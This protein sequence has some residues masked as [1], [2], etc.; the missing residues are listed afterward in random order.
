MEIVKW[1]MKNLKRINFYCQ[2]L[3]IILISLSLST[4]LVSQTNVLSFQHLSSENG[5]AQVNI[6]CI[7][8]DKD[9]F[10][11]ISSNNGISRY[12]GHSLKKLQYI[13]DDSIQ[14]KFNKTTCIF[15]DHKSRMLIGN[16]FNV[17]LYDFST[18]MLKSFIKDSSFKNKLGN[19]DV[20]AITEDETGTIWIGTRKGLFEYQEKNNSFKQYLHDTILTNNEDYY[21]NRITDLLPDMHGTIWIG[22]LY[23]VYKFSIT[24]HQFTEP[25]KIDF[26]L[27]SHKDRIVS[28]EFD[29]NG[30]LWLSIYEHGINILDTA[31][32]EVT[33]IDTKTTNGQLNSNHISKLICDESGKM[34]IAH[35]TKGINLY[36]PDTK[37]FESFHHDE[38]DAQ[39]LIDDRIN[40]IFKD[41][42][43]TIWI[44]TETEGIDRVSRIQSK[45]NTYSHHSE[46]SNSPC[47]NGIL[48]ACE[49]SKNNLWIGSI[50]GLM[51]FDRLKNS[52]TCFHHEENN[53]NSLSDNKIHSVSI[54][55]KGLVW[56]GTESG[57]NVYNPISG[58]WKHYFP[59]TKNPG[60]LSSS[61]INKICIRRN[62]EIWFGTN[63][64]ICRYQPEKDQ[65]ETKNN[66]KNISHIQNEFYM[67]LYEDSKGSIWAA[68]S[69]GGVLNLADSFKI[70]KKYAVNSKD[71][72][73][74]PSNSVFDFAE[75]N[76]GN[77][78]MA[79][80]E[81]I[82]MLD[83]KT[84]KFNIYTTSDG[85]AS[86]K[87]TQVKIADDGKIWVGTN[88]GL[89]ELF[90]DKNGKALIKNFNSSDGLQ[91]NVFY[92][93]ASLKLHSG[94]FLFGGSK[95]FNLF[96]PED[97]VFNNKIPNVLLSSF[98]ILDKEIDNLSQVIDLK[99]LKLSHTQNFFSFDMAAISFDYPEKNQYA[100]QL[101]GFDKTMIHC[102]NR[103][104]VS[105]T[106]VPPGNYTL[107]IIA[108]NN[109][110]VWNYEGL[111][112]QI[113]ITPPYWMTW[114]F[115]GFVFAILFGS[116]ILLVRY[117]ST[118]KLKKQLVFIE[119][120]REI[121]NIRS[122][123]SRDIHDEIGSGLTR[124]TALGEMMKSDINDK[125]ESV[126]STIN[127]I[128]ASSQEIT[129]NLSEIVWTINPQYDNLQSLLSYLRY[130]SS[131]FFEDSTIKCIISFP[132]D[133]LPIQIHPDIKRNIFLAIKE[134]LNNIMKHSQAKNV[135][136]TFEI[137]V[138]KFKLIIADD[139]VGFEERGNNEFGNGLR[140]I[141]ARMQG[142]KAS[143]SI[144]SRPGKGTTII[145]EGYLE[146]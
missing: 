43:G 9:G 126:P 112:I 79:T 76:N 68:T 64:S 58:K 61:I 90:F 55:R 130:Y 57:L 26:D 60:S 137:E 7:N 136:I 46:H 33:I 41:D 8:Q 138:R 54:D 89:S 24:T 53:S 118:R 92:N 142:I 133:V 127:K 135:F 87:I 124:I 44:G 104:H 29:K 31:T 39:S 117:I 15:R 80:S 121:E 2:I 86:N 45:F 22:T 139:G 62:G 106:N 19:F 96:H 10:I 59:D 98:S 67:A 74:I 114:Y 16:G 143:C 50:N 132:S 42:F 73:S 123:I 146:E 108:S 37:Y 109:D 52:F 14:V 21:R 141:S 113:E 66:S 56:I 70:I 110:G 128:I 51:Y 47:E 48:S 105:Y 28:E 82:A 120:Q 71:P 63:N 140:N 6:S 13:G 91:S 88:A 95:G 20:T 129:G 25:N 23:G 83:R 119:Q 81:G 99:K 94:E 116:L 11:W 35:D 85:L 145:I 4:S 100:Y 12:D 134:S 103:Y 102:G 38:P 93:S 84:Q 17:L 3:I 1:V 122:R 101:E 69:R 34:W 65:F 30:H 77:I 18:G 40:T 75:D 115:R 107:H 72:H 131:A 111:R 36:Y 49:D 144:E 5:S 78:W 32:N 97:I 27:Y 125:S